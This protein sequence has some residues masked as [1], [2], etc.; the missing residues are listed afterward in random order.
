MYDKLE[1]KKNFDNMVLYGNIGNQF[2]S[3]CEGVYRGSFIEH[4]F[5]EYDNVNIEILIAA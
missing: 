1:S 5:S 2:H 4:I 3:L